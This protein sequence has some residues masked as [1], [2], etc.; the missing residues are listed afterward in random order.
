MHRSYVHHVYVVPGPLIEFIYVFI[1]VQ[2]FLRKFWKLLS[3]AALPKLALA[4]PR[5]ESPFLSAYLAR[6]PV[7]VHI[8]LSE[9][10]GDEQPRRLAATRDYRAV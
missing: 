2:I 9:V 3:L 8:G 5:A 4:V 10:S 6:P 7:R 1:L